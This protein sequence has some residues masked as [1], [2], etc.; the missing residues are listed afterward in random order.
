MLDTGCWT[1]DTG[2]WIHP[3]I[4]KAF[5]LLNSPQYQASSIH[6]PYFFF[7]N[8]FSLVNA[9]PASTKAIILL[10]LPA[11]STRLL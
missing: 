9:K 6:V 4:L 8:T 2:Y 5:L 3:A 10:Q 1:L 7:N 11:G